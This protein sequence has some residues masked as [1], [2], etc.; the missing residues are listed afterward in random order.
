MPTQYDNNG[1]TYFLTQLASS[2]LHSLSF[3]VLEILTSASIVVLNDVF[4]FRSVCNTAVVPGSGL[5]WPAAQE[6]GD[7][8]PA[9]GGVGA[10]RQDIRAVVV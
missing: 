9:R 7:Q 3:E 5:A 2:G 1:A 6:E 8:V 4:C 10:E